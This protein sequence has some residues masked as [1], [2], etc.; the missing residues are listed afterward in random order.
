MVKN[1][2]YQIECSM[3]V[4]RSHENTAVLTILPLKYTF[5]IDEQVLWFLFALFMNPKFK[6][7]IYEYSFHSV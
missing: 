3:D 6:R 4:E 5:K 2:T 1:S 7:K